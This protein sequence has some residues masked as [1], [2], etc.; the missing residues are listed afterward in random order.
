MLWAEAVWNMNE[1]LQHQMTDARVEMEVLR[2]EMAALLRDKDELARSPD[3]ICVRVL[4]SVAFVVDDSLIGSCAGVGG[5]R[6][7]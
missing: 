4:A 2:E 7:R 6:G 5:I 1:R 3:E